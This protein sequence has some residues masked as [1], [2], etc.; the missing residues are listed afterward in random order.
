[1]HYGWIKIFW[2][3]WSLYKH[4]FW[5][6]VWILQ[7]HQSLDLDCPQVK[8]CIKIAL[9]CVDN[10]Q[11]KRPTIRNIIEMLNGKETMIEM[12][13]TVNGNSRNNSGSSIKKVPV[14][15]HGEPGLTGTSRYCSRLLFSST[16]VLRSYLI[17]SCVLHFFCRQSQLMKPIRWI[18]M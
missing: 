7:W 5:F 3:H 15:K 14:L 17:S 13:S 12:V 16:G 6:W 1:M 18:F 8:T 2:K 9:L 11:R 10:D 4:I